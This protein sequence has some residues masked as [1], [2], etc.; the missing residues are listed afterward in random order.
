MHNPVI[1]SFA[2]A[3]G[4]KDHTVLSVEILSTYQLYKTLQLKKWGL[5]ISVIVH[6]TSVVICSTNVSILYVCDGL[7]P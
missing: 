1:T 6:G 4:V 3:K 2:V 7:W 5:W